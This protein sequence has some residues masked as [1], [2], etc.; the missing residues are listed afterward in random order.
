[1]QPTPDCTPSRTPTA[2]TTGAAVNNPGAQVAACS[3]TE[4]GALE[5][6]K[7]NQQNKYMAQMSQQMRNSSPPLMPLHVLEEPQ[8]SATR[9]PAAPALALAL[10]PTLALAVAPAAAPALALA[11]SAP[12]P[13]TPALS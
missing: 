13:H 3:P 1:M 9:C 11:L 8:R 7:P 12:Q 2:T 5:S 6:A 4:P 10:A